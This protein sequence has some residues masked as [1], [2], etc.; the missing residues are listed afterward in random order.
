VGWNDNSKKDNAFHLDDDAVLVVQNIVA[1]DDPLELSS[2]FL[3]LV[4]VSDLGT[5]ERPQVFNDKPPLFVEGQAEV[6][7]GHALDV[8]NNVAV[9][10]GA[11]DETSVG[12]WN[13]AEFD[14]KAW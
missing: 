11:E 5:Y 3:P 1:A 7:L 8:H 13:V 9:F 2:C 12:S 4:I 14:G 6:A 10:A